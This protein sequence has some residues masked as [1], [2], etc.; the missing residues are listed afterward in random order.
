MFFRKKEEELTD[1]FTTYK[2]RDMPRFAT[3]AEISVKG[4]EGEGLL[5]NVSST[6]C[7]MES[8]T[9]VA[10]KPAEVHQVSI[11]PDSGDKKNGSFTLELTVSWTRSSETSFEAGFHLGAGQTGALLKQYTETL[12]SRGVSPEYG[13]VSEGK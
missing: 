7:C 5:K 11:N 2:E 13:N 8:V 9:Y 1:Q 10:V 3:N 12:K 6:G 4:F